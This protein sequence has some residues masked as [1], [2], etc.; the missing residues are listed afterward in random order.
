MGTF[1]R[2]QSTQLYSIACEH[3]SAKAILQFLRRWQMN[4]HKQY[5]P[6]TFHTTKEIIIVYK[7]KLTM[8][9]VSS[10]HNSVMANT[11]WLKLAMIDAYP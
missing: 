7:I 5:W 1:N 6:R 9:T 11:T 8:A 2:A 10:S 4:L 3:P